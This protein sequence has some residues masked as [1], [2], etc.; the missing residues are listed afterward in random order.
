MGQHTFK[1]VLFRPEGVGTWTYVAI[2]FDLAAEAGK[3]GQVRVKGT[4]NGYSYRSTALPR[5]D[6]FHYLV[7][8]QA[9]RGVLGVSPGDEVTVSIELDP[10]ERL[11]EI[12]LDFQQALADHPEANAH[13]KNLAAS[14]QKEYVRWITDAK[15]EETRAKRITQTIEKLKSNM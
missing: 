5:G 10:Q 14:H 13:F 15:R 11:V 8:N 4:I 9:I 2:P 1:G 6:G 12:P 7:V 3:R